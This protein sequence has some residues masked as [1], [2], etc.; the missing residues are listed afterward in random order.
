MKKWLL[1]LMVTVLSLC[2]LV[3]CGPKDPPESSSKRPDESTVGDG[4]VVVTYKWGVKTWGTEDD[5]L[6]PTEYKYS[7]EVIY[8]KGDDATPQDA[9]FGE[10]ID[11]VEGYEFYGWSKEFSE[12]KDIQEN[13]VVTAQ[14]QKLAKFNF[15]F[16]NQNGNVIFSG[17]AWQGSD[18]TSLAPSTTAPI[19]YFQDAA[20][21]TDPKEYKVDAATYYIEAADVDKQETHIAVPIGSYF[22]GWTS[23]ERGSTVNKLAADNTVFTARLGVTDTVISY[24]KPGTIT[25]DNLLNQDLY[26]ELENISIYKQLIQYGTDVSTR[27]DFSIIDKYDKLAADSNGKYADGLAAATADGKATEYSTAVTEWNKYSSGISSKFYMAWDGEFVYFMAEI[28]D[29]KVITHGAQ[30]STIANPY[31][32]DSIELWYYFS[33]DRETKVCLDACGYKMYSGHSNP[34]AYLDYMN[35]QGLAQAKVVDASGNEIDVKTDK[36]ARVIAGATGYTVAFAFPARTEPTNPTADM[37]NK[38]NWGTQMKRG[39]TFSVSLQVNNL[40]DV[41]RDEL[42]QKAISSGTTDMWKDC[43]PEERAAINEVYLGWQAHKKGAGI[44]TFVLG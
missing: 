31:E 32:N 11:D 40:S 1:F 26:T 3:A 18:L 38:A 24:V 8:D 35:Q 43:T 34:S 5:A 29:A 28:K 41:A 22:L 37:T 14:Y 33:G 10:T 21:L 17:T 2:A 42:I 23:S 12:L 44:M 25:K 9:G 36:S 15:T 4:K 19:Y 20:T 30:Y 39:D 16:K 27:Q 7:K 6:Y 13:M